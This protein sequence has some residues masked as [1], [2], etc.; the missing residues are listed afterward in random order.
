MTPS[1]SA[2]LCSGRYCRFKTATQGSEILNTAFATYGDV[3]NPDKF[4][5]S[6]LDT[7]IEP[8]F[9]RSHTTAI[10]RRQAVA[11]TKDEKEEKEEA[12]Q[13]DPGVDG[14]GAAAQTFDLQ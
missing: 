12:A 11:I 14:P 10:D 2:V 3:F 6:I 13:T 9:Q 1:V 5:S 8:I 4:D 7:D